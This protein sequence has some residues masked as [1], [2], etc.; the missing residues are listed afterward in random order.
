MSDHFC[1]FSNRCCLLYHDRCCFSTSQHNH[2]SYS[3]SV[4]DSIGKHSSA[5]TLFYQYCLLYFYLHLIWAAFAYLHYCGITCFG[6]ITCLSNHMYLQEGCDSQYCLIMQLFGRLSLLCLFMV[7]LIPWF[8]F[9]LIGKR[10]LWNILLQ[11]NTINYRCMCMGRCV[12]NV[13]NYV[14]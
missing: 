3:I 6:C 14:I 8:A 1:L 13:S 9:A 2:D 11:I 5:Q 10:N 12:S 7:K 4:R